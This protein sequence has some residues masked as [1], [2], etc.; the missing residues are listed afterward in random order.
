MNAHVEAPRREHPLA[1]LTRAVEGTIPNP[2]L[3]L[4]P[5]LLALGLL[6]IAPARIASDTW[7][8]LAAGLRH[9]P[10]RPSALGSADGLHRRPA[11]AGSAVAR[12]SHDLRP[13]R[14]RRPAARLP[15]GRRVPRRRPV[16]RHA[17]RAAPRRLA[18]VDRR[19]RDPADP[20]PGSVGGARADVRDAALR[21]ARVAARARC[22][23]AGPQDP[24]RHPAARRVG[25]R[26]RERAARVRARAA[27]LRRGR[28][29]R[30]A[31]S[32]SARARAPRGNRVRGAR[33]ALRIAVRLRP[34]R[35]LPGDA[36]ERCAP[37]HRQRV[38]GDDAAR[39][40]RAALLRVRAV[41]IVAILRPEIRLRCSTACASRH[42]CSSASTRFATSSG[43]RTPPWC[44]CRPRSPRGRRSR[45]RARGCSRCSCGRRS[46]ARSARAC[47][48]GG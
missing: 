36:D 5:L 31:R 18:D 29:P 17:R 45:R 16:A 19:A 26:P 12:A 25:E 23:H 46:P 47:S 8:G 3:A 20:H 13:L 21:G 7:F 10:R 4:P 32:R 37:Q 2:L 34:A 11:L 38:G 9:R 40:V 30:A 1:R 41:A 48:R 22:A 15:G 33:R 14:P 35:L 27:A 28:R 6:S 42:S 43:C 24:A 44:C 39:V